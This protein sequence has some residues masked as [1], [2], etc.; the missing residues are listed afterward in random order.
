[1]YAGELDPSLTRRTRQGT[2]LNKT[3]NKVANHKSTAKAGETLNVR[4]P[5]FS[6]NTVIYP[7]SLYLSYKFKLTTEGDEEDVP[8]H[9]VNAIVENFKLQ[10]N[11]KTITEINS[12]NK[13]AIYRDLWM[14]K[15]NYENM[16]LEQGINQSDATKKK[17]HGVTGAAADLL[18]TQYSER[19]RFYLGHFLADTASNPESI[20]GDVEF[21]LK[22]TT[23][24]YTLED[25]SLEYTSVEDEEL[26]SSIV[27][28]YSK[29]NQ[30][31]LS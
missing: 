25:I 30:R 14:Q 26:A 1:M 13:F 10:I 21:H 29:T 2:K 31:V 6:K 22:L 11:G 5:K 4:I 15:F 9:L 16:C 18:G 19:Y 12:F 27:Q 7:K 28:K 20:M 24:K 23:G 8:D 17:R 3:H